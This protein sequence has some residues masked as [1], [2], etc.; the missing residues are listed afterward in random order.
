MKI[1]FRLSLLIILI[2]FQIFAQSKSTSKEKMEAYLFV[3]FTGNNKTEEAI[4]FAISKDGYTYRA[5]NHDN[6][7][8][9]STKISSTGGV[10]DPH[11]LRGEDGNFFYMV[12]TDMESAKGWDSNRA[13]VL[14][15]SKD[16]INWTS[17]VV[18]IQ[19]RFKGQDN[20]KRVWAPQTIYDAKAKKYMIYWSM[21]HGNQPD[22]IYYAYANKDFTDLE[23]EPKQLFFSPTNGSCICRYCK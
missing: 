10:R 4:H 12:A 20:L 16:L 1:I 22:V 11:I 5:L 8:I 15:K 7:V 14:L 19:T 6:P 3:Y 17:K 13:M 18:N 9:T 21:K 23:S 2:P